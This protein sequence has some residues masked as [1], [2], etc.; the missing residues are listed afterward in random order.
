MHHSLTEAGRALLASAAVSAL[1]AGAPVGAARAE[2]PYVRSGTV[3]DIEIDRLVSF[4]DSYS[5]LNRKTRFRNFV[6]Q[7][8]DEGDASAI[9][10][11]G[12]SGATAANVEVNGSRKSFRQ[13]LNKWRN[14]GPV[15]GQRHA[16][17]VYFGYNDINNF[18]DLT[19]SRRD[20]SSG[21]S[22]LASNG[23]TQG[24]RHVF[25]FQVHDWGKNPGQASNPTCDPGSTKSCRQQLR[26][27]TQ[28]W[29]NHVA[30]VANLRPNTIAV[31]LFTAFDRIIAD[32]G[33]YGLTNVATADPT[34]S[35]TTALFDDDNHFGGRGQDL[36][37]QVFQHYL[38]RA[39]DWSHAL[40]AGAQAA[41]QLDRDITDGVVFNLAALAEEQRPGLSA[42]AI[43]ELADQPAELPEEHA[44]DVTRAG[45]AQVYHPDE[46]PDGGVALNYA[47]SDGT[48]LGVVI[49][50]YAES[51]EA[52]HELAS[53]SSTITSDAACTSATGWG[54]ST[55]SAVWS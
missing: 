25:L 51:V 47:V 11:L 34:R 54:T 19:Q 20:Y 41:Q 1:A 9:Q 46:R 32:P 50:R 44:A 15:F 35:N 49:G 27:R 55:C 28:G 8:R 12:V 23:A 21:V 3:D 43:G 37:Q 40:A 31:D 48:A 39:W 29:N 53:S 22:T 6:E 4:G 38:T 42:F 10:G 7:M 18:T 33:R 45:F 52:E 30:A 16:T 5:R 2:S 17:V 14:A 36:I 13:Q 26:E 24:D